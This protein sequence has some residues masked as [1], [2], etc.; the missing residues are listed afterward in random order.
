MINSK[1]SKKSLKSRSLKLKNKRTKKTKVFRKNFKNMKGGTIDDEIKESFKHFILRNFQPEIMK[2]ATEK[3]HYI[4]ILDFFDNICS[5]FYSSLYTAGNYK[6]YDYLRHMK[7]ENKQN[8]KQN[9]LKPVF[10]EIINIKIKLI[11][12]K[13]ASKASQK[14]AASAE[15]N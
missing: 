9:L 4:P 11:N 3:F 2:I 10:D 12:E 15:N 1:L 13:K 6:L 7:P 8:Y 5:T 14:L